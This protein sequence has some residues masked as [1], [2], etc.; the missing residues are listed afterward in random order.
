MTAAHRLLPAPSPAAVRLV[1]FDAFDTLARPRQPPHIQYA[2]E[3]RALGVRWAPSSLR[4][5]DER[6]AYEDE[7]IRVAFKEGVPVLLLT[8]LSLS[9]HLQWEQAAFKRTLAEHPRYGLSTGLGSPSAWWALLINSTFTALTAH[10]PPPSLTT[11][12]LARFASARAY[13][14]FDDVLPALAQL[15]SLRAP[16]CVCV[17]VGIA[18]N[19]D[20][21]ILSALG[22]LGLGEH[23]N[24]GLTSSS[25]SS[26]TEEPAPV[27]SYTAPAEKP[28]PAFFQHAL[29]RASAHLRLATPLEP[30]Q[31]LYVGDQLHEDYWAAKDAGLRAL[32][33]RR[34]DSGAAA[35]SNQPVQAPPRVAG[36][37]GAEE[38]EEVGS[39][40]EMVD[41]VRRW[42]GPAAS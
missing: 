36:R 6:R 5:E 7:A 39:L 32:W 1:L 26:R 41:I 24:L 23:M 13:A 8:I 27:L 34:R 30:H 9:Y 31:A 20:A 2:N 21:A 40:L 22:A 25:S 10:P 15:R 42:N 12:L 35:A 4:G 11:A 37:E 38:G 19:S 29:E 33:L 3:A 16:S 17:N 18:T 14:L 28:H